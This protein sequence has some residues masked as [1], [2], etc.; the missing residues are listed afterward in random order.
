VNPTFSAA[1]LLFLAAAIAGSYA[2]VAISGVP[3]VSRKVVPFSGV[4]LLLV[5]L[6]WVLPELA[7]DFG[8]A[9]GIALMTTGFLLLGLVDKFVYPVCPSCS[10][11][12]DHDNCVT[13][14]HGFAGPL[15]AATVI[16]SLF[17]GWA[18][19]AAEAAGQ[20]GI[21]AGV[22]LHKLPES[23]AFGIILRAAL[24]SRQKAIVSAVLV[25]MATLI[26]VGL[27]YVAEPHMGPFWIHVLLAIAGGTFLYLGFHA[28]HSEWKR[29]TMRAAT[30]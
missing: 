22:L 13:R 21:S 6:V 8:W 16:H 4:M 12:H 29:R 5:S 19:A 7:E 25:Q 17:D 14:L 24:K 10:H 26:G 20:Q 30:H 27:E 18:L 11:T 9:P 15:L 2:G 23:V 28:V 3:E 1:L